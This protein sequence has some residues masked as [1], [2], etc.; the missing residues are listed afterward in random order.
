[1]KAAVFQNHPCQTESGRNK[2]QCWAAKKSRSDVL[3]MWNF[4]TAAPL[5][6]SRLI[7]YLRHVCRLW[8][9]NLSPTLNTSFTFTKAECLMSPWRS[10][11]AWRARRTGGE[12][13]SWRGGEVE[14]WSATCLQCQRLRF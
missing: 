13:E 3:K 6:A 9:S 1:M 10:T 11:G 4:P 2:K 7:K 12:A 14:R 8:F 5:N